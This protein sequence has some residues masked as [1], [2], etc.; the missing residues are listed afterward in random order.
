MTETAVF[1][2]G[3]FWCLEAIFRALKG[4]VSVRSG[5]CGGALPDPV[6]KRFVAEA[7][8]TPRWSK[9][10]SIHARLVMSRCS[11]VFLGARPN[12]AESSGERHRYAVSLG[13]FQSIGNAEATRSRPA[14]RR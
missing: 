8:V 9:L 14:S 10:F 6:T 5:Y 7:P 1:G 12:D 11:T 4:V 2:G 13:D 3:C